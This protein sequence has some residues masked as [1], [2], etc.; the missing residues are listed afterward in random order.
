MSIKKIST[1][2]INENPCAKTNV[3]ADEFIATIEKIL[4]PK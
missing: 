2:K 3:K 1:M 4:A